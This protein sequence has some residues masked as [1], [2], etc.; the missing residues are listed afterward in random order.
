MNT[1]FEKIQEKIAPTAE[2]NRKSK[3]LVIHT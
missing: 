2:K 3:A 1:F